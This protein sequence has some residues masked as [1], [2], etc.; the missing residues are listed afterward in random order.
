MASA[1][2]HGRVFCCVGRNPLA[3][4]ITVDELLADPEPLDLIVTRKEKDGSLGEATMRVYPRRPT[5]IEQSLCASAANHARRAQRK[6]LADPKSDEHQLLLVDALEDADPKQLRELWIS[7]KLIEAAAQMQVNSLEER[8]VVPEPEG[9]VI[10]PKER[11]AYDEAVE[12]A[13]S[14]RMDNLVKAI[15]SE[16]RRL[17]E[18]A[19]AIPDG[20]LRENAI[21]AHIET[22]VQRTWNDVYTAHIIQRG[23][24]ADAKHRRE[25]F[26]TISQVEAFRARYPAAFRRLA[27]THQG[28]LLEME[29]TLG[30]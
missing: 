27:D 16:R 5:E 22:I 10:T 15:E 29:P 3:E 30:N 7:G 4:F 26:K 24:F 25:Y 13:E 14:D 9:E 6:R 20:A 12:Q 28:L 23:T 21:P 19:E 2:A 11:D 18:E 1:N 8:E 17:E